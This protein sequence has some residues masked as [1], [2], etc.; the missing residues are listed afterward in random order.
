MEA[1][2]PDPITKSYIVDLA[3]KESL[4][5]IEKTHAIVLFNLQKKADKKKGGGAKKKP[6]AAPAPAAKESKKRPAPAPAVAAIVEKEKK[7]KKEK[8]EGWL[9]EGNL[10]AGTTCD[11]EAEDQKFPGGGTRHNGSTHQVCKACRKAMKKAEKEA[12]E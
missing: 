11:L 2:R 6:A 1:E 10:V 12:A 4:I 8:P 7:P 9:C 5:N 3:K